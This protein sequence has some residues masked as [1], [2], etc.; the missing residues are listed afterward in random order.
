MCIFISTENPLL[1]FHLL[2]SSMDEK[3][4]RVPFAEDK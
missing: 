4:N 2:V 3:R 1:S